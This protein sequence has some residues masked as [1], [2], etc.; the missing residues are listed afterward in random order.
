MPWEEVCPGLALLHLSKTEAGLKCL[1]EK[2]G[3]GSPRAVAAEYPWYN[4]VWL[5]EILK[6]EV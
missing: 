4:A 2:S 5:P 3:A 6:Q 1:G